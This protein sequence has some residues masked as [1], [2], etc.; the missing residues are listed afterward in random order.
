MI[1]SD[2]RFIAARVVE[3]IVGGVLLVAGLIKAYEMLD[4]VRQVLSYNIITIPVLVTVLVWLLVVGECGL[5][6]A[7]I[8]GYL[9]R[10]ALIATFALFTVFL[11]FVG[12]SWYSG[13]TEN[14][15]C[16]G[17]KMK[18]SPKEAFIFDGVL[19][20]A[21]VITQ[22]LNWQRDKDSKTSQGSGN[23]QTWK[24]A[25][26]IVSIVLGLG[27][28]TYASFS[29]KQSADPIIRLN[30][31]QPNPFQNVVVSG[32]TVDLQKGLQV[33]VLMDT[34]CDHCQA[35]VPQFNEIFEQPTNF[36]PLTAICSNSPLDVKDFQRKF[37]AKF[38]LGRISTEDFL[39]LLDKGET[40]RIFLLQDGKVLKIWDQQS[41][42]NDELK[43][44]LPK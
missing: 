5:G 33:V 35:N 44:A 24:L 12:W 13:S 36:P 20:I 9:R 22:L 43:I 3:I 21:L 31:T 14:C 30:V 18:H 32:L 41:P 7:L 6:S 25:T 40:P 8:V 28:A 4:S 2:W 23:N 17:S 42:T 16:F 27:V 19:V 29:P 10:Y 26:V 37:N 39:K 1:T 38:P 34:A 15:G 11:S